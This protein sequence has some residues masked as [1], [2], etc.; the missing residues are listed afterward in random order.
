MY[1][2][3]YDTL[4]PAPEDGAP[5]DPGTD[6]QS[7]FTSYVFCRSAADDTPAKPASTMGSFAS[8]SPDGSGFK[9]YKIGSTT[10]AYYWYDGIPSDTGEHYPV[11]MSS[12]IFTSDG[13]SPQQSA[14]SKPKLMTDSAY[15]DVEYST[16]ESPSAPS[17]HPNTNLVSSG[18]DWSN[19]PSSDVIWMA[20]STCANGA[21]SDWVVARIKGENGIGTSI[22]FRYDRVKPETPATDTLQG[23]FEAPTKFEPE[24]SIEMDETNPWRKA[25]DGYYEIDLNGSDTTNETSCDVTWEANAAGQFIVI[26]MVVVGQ[27]NGYADGETPVAMSF[28]IESQTNVQKLSHTI[29]NKTGEAYLYLYAIEA[30]DCSIR[31]TYSSA[32]YLQPRWRRIPLFLCYASTATVSAKGIYRFT[33]PVIYIPDTNSTESVYLLS[34]EKKVPDTPVSDHYE[35]DFIPPLYDDYD[36]TMTY[37]KGAGVTYNKKAWQ[38]IVNSCTGQTPSSGST[39]WEQVPTWTDEPQNPTT[40]H[41]YQ[42]AAVRY[43]ENAVWGDFGTPYLFTDKGL[44]GDTGVGIAADTMYFQATNS[45]AAPAVTVVSGKFSNKAGKWSTASQP[46]SADTPYLWALRVVDYTDGTQSRSAPYIAG[47]YSSDIYKATKVP[48]LAGVWQSTIEYTPTEYETPYVYHNGQYYVLIKTSSSKGENPSAETSTDVWAHMEHYQQLIV[49]ALVADLARIGGAVYYG[50]YMFSQ[51]GDS[52]DKGSDKEYQDAPEVPQYI[53]DSNDFMPY[54][55]IDFKTGTI[56][57]RKAYIEGKVAATSG[58]FKNGTFTD[59]NAV[60]GT[61]TNVTVTGDFTAN[62]SH[63]KLITA[64][65]DSNGK[66]FIDLNKQ[67]GDYII[68]NGKATTVYLPDLEVGEC[69]EY[70]VVNSVSSS[71]TE[72]LTVLTMAFMYRNDDSSAKYISGSN[73]SGTTSGS[74]GGTFG[75]ISDDYEIAGTTKEVGIY[76]GLGTNGVASIPAGQFRLIGYCV[77]EDNIEW[78]IIK[79]DSHTNASGKSL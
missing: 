50:D 40:S 77:D 20:T 63:H 9:G 25:A 29:N 22:R 1:L 12:R 79:T 76:Y 17:G 4:M 35:T 39:Y 23:W 33:E 43:K 57:A 32:G 28:K 3:A 14:W 41:P 51:Y 24:I 67:K 69:R 55:F 58:T 71:D 49:N 44:T 65:A 37:S 74:D 66:L 60:N 47:N 2:A 5:G 10:K 73:G 30:G 11:W 21:W 26:H 34:A 8:P 18:G 64:T 61:F 45:T 13:E 68:G 56:Y 31:M 15:F 70:T 38:C 19:E 54:L 59:C 72:V 75:G 62:Y 52:A 7:S 27:D 16:K 6:G 48:Y 36:S 42:Y 78:R 53:E 46:L